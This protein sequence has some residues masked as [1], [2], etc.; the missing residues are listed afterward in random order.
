MGYQFKM[1]QNSKSLYK[2]KVTRHSAPITKGTFK[3]YKISVAFA[4]YFY[5]ALSSL[6]FSPDQV[7]KKIC[8]FFEKIL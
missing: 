2:Y 7:Q 1:N 8:D 5:Y 3:V 4:I 6:P